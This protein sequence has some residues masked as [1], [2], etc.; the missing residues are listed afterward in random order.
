MSESSP[1]TEESN[2]NPNPEAEPLVPLKEYTIEE[3]A[4]HNE[5][6]NLW[7]ML[8]GR[9]VNVSAFDDHPGGPDVFESVAGKDG[10]DDFEQICHS[11]TAKKQVQDY[12]IG[13]VKGQE[14]KDLML[15]NDSED[16]TSMVLAIIVVLIALGAYFYFQ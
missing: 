3:I 15:I 9:V 5:E 16:S 6:G 7:F 8:G 2:S 12:V 13:K 4:K 11:N 14:V 1:D 10:T